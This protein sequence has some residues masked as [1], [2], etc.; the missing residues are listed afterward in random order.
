MVQR[1]TDRV[2]VFRAC[3]TDRI[4]IEEMADFAKWANQLGV[5]SDPRDH[6]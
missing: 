2:A 3:W 6:T 1:G 5:R 4:E